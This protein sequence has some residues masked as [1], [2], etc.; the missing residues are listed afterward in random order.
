MKAKTTIF[1]LAFVFVCFSPCFAKTIIPFKGNIDFQ[2]KQFDVEFN[3]GKKASFSLKTK[4]NS[5]KDF[6]AFLSIEHLRTKFFDLSSQIKSSLEILKDESGEIDRIEGKLLSSYS[7][8]DYKPAKELSGKFTLKNKRLDLNVFFFDAINCKG[9]ID[10]AS[11]LGVDL[12]VDLLSVGLDKFLD[13]WMSSRKFEAEG[14]VE[15]EIQATGTLNNLFLRASLQSYDGSIGKFKYNSI[16]LNAGGIYPY[17]QIASSTAS[18]EDGSSFTI[19]GPFNLKDKENYRKQIR[20]L[21]LLPIVTH[22]DS[23]SEWTIKRSEDE[24]SGRTE[25]KYLFREG[26]DGSSEEDSDMFGIERIMEF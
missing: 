14:K 6:D 22:S 9:Y 26:T 4:K 12:N 7:L 3:A 24:S 13:F 18:S 20:E 15:G 10:L 17:L 2:N 1:L 25:L 19:D 23:D 8:I 11:D 21:N 16:Y 5:D